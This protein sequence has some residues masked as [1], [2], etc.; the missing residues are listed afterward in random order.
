MSDFKR[1]LKRILNY[2][3]IKPT[4]PLLD[5]FYSTRFNYLD[6][7]ISKNGTSSI[8]A[9]IMSYDFEVPFDNEKK[10][11]KQHG[12]YRSYN[13]QFRLIGND[14]RPE[15][16]ERFE[17]YR[18]FIVLRDPMDR[19]ISFINNTHK[20]DEYR[21]LIKMTDSPEKYVDSVL[22]I[23]PKMINYESKD[24]RYDKHA[25]PQRVYYEKYRAIFGDS[26][27]VVWLKDLPEFFEGIT[28]LPLVKNNVTAKSQY[29]C[30]K[31]SL[32]PKQLDTINGYIQ[33][34]EFPIQDEYTMLFKK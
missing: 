11:W 1:I 13:P 9:S 10:I 8:L 30:T 29:V 26:L 33:K 4:D 3:Q 7:G 24:L 6:C 5:I 20:E 31:D 16:M 19:F 28:G 32:T 12:V 18:K 27:E 17:G 34:Y 14:F 22:R 23:F 25:V 2:H 21:Y 15:D